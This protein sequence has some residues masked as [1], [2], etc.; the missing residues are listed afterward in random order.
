MK[1]LHKIADQMQAFL[2]EEGIEKYA[3]QV[4]ESEKQEMNA[5][6]G[7]FSLFRTVIDQSVVVEAYIGSRKGSVRG[8]DATEEGLRKLAEEA[9]LSAQSAEEDP[10]N[11]FAPDE[12]RECFEKGALE[13]DMDKFFF[14][15][16][17]LMDTIKEEHPRIQ[18]LMVVGD[19]TK[20]HCLYRNTHGTEFEETRGSYDFVIEMAGHEGDITTGLDYTSFTT[21]TLDKPFMEMGD[22]KDHIKSAEDSLNQT[23]L[24]G[25]FE[26]PVIFTPG[27]LANFLYMLL[28]NYVFEGVILDGT[29]QWIDKVGEKVMSESI[30]VS[31]KPSDKR[32]VAGESFTDDG[33]KTEDVQIISKGVLCG[34]VLGLY[35][36]NKTG[37]PVVKNTGMDLVMEGGDASLAEMI[38]SVKQ[39]LLVGGFSGGQPGANGEFS[40]VAKNSF[41]IEDGKIQGAVTEVMINGNL[42]NIFNQVEAISQEVGCDGS[43]VVPYIKVGGVVISGK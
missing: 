9:K 16:K 41:Y 22:V 24:P 21:A 34:H 20:R 12:G 28:S 38:S 4:I 6:Y 35:V 13:P 40:G 10:A 7:H 33:F 14:R 11:D 25:K 2:K 19:Y 15:T 31:L 18:L 5:E 37:R 8:N 42:E 29:S 27:C 30:N 43:M 23:K 32:I 36:A 1:D 26:G 17:E 39:G 3:L